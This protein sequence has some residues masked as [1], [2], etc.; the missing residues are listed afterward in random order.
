MLVLAGVLSSQMWPCGCLLKRVNHTRNS[1]ACRSRPTIRKVN[2]L[3]VGNDEDLNTK[4][5]ISFA[6]IVAHEDPLRCQL[7]FQA[8]NALWPCNRADWFHHL[9]SDPLPLAPTTRCCL[10]AECL[11]R[12]QDRRFEAAGNAFRHVGVPRMNSVVSSDL[13]S[14][15]LPSR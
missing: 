2:S 10:D 9:R 4:P 13:G 8:T 7:H 15:T 12:W 3:D 14:N 1:V 11:F 6:K 5:K